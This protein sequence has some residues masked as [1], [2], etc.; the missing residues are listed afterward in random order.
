MCTPDDY[1]KHETQSS[2]VVL[3]FNPTNRFIYDII[4]YIN[5]YVCIL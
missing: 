1:Q 4:K 2:V 3:F 5:S